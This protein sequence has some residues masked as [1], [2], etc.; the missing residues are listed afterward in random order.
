MALNG[1]SCYKLCDIVNVTTDIFIAVFIVGFVIVG[2]YLQ[3]LVLSGPLLRKNYT[4][5]MIILPPPDPGT[6]MYV[7]ILLNS[8][9]GNGRTQKLS[10][11]M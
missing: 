2:Y 9:I 6:Y 3:D 5:I 10:N 1:A 8:G 7:A 11:E 4:I